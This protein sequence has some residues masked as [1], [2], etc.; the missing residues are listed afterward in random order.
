MTAV[1]FYI[2]RKSDLNESTV[3]LEDAFRNNLQDLTLNV[4][5][6]VDTSDLRSEKYKTGIPWDSL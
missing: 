1:L 3:V 4:A 6:V 2:L 5:G